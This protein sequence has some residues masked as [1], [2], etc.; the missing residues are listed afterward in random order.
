V[1]Q[2][3]GPEFKSL[4]WKEGRKER[5][6]KERKERKKEKKRKMEVTAVFSMN[7]SLKTAGTRQKKSEG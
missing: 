7:L 3:I 6:G 5:K 2:D 1:A 4:Y